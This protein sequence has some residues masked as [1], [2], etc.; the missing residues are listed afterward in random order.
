MA[1]GSTS[2]RLRA[3]CDRA[4]APCDCRDSPSPCDD[5]GVPHALREVADRLEL[6]GEPLRDGAFERTLGRARDLGWPEVWIR[7]HGAG[8]VDARAAARLRELG[9]HGVVLPV[10][11]QTSR[12]HDR[13]A[14]APD[15]LVT[16]LRAM[17][18]ARCAP[19]P[20]PR[21]PIGSASG[22]SIA[23]ARW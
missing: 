9:A 15:A 18:A 23:P 12:V 14:G 19:S 2:V 16:A 6:R 22:S 4:C 10:F 5:G 20:R 17:R 7:S 1:R 3:R 21:G 13:V 8:L 11:S